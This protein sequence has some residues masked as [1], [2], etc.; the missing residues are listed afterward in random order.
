MT[1]G[2]GQPNDANVLDGPPGARDNISGDIERL[3]GTDGIDLI[4]GSP[5]NDRM[6]GGAANDRMTWNTVAGSDLMQGG[7]G[8]DVTEVNGAD[9]AGDVFTIAADGDRVAFARTNLGPFTLDI[10]T[11]ERLE[12]NGQGGDDTITGGE[13]LEGLIRLK[14][15]GGAGNDTITGSAGDDTIVGGAGN[16]VLKGGAGNDTYEVGAGHGFDSFSDTGGT[17]KIT[18]TADNVAIGLQSG[19]AAIRL[20]AVRSPRSAHRRRSRRRGLRGCSDGSGRPRHGPHV[21]TGPT[22]RASRRNGPAES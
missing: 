1:L 7:T 18:A 21:R 2:K 4:T 22:P 6:Y 16:D 8:Y 3:V 10:G 13:G 19:F 12:V 14:L 17:D 20:R 15:D 9:T 11:T 5:G